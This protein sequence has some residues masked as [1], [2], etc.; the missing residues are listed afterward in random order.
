MTELPK[1]PA[2]GTTSPLRPMSFL[3]LALGGIIQL[4]M[5][6]YFLVLRPH[7]LPKDGRYLG[8]SFQQLS[9]DISALSL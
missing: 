1:R 4:G 7:L 9:N 6:F 3:I 2:R 5:G 8:Q